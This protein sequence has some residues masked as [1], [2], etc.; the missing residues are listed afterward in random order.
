M[1]I[2]NS[3]GFSIISF[4]FVLGVMIFIHELGHYAV[5]KFLGIR[6]E[7][8]SLGFGRR[9]VGFKKGDT[10]YRICLLPL[11]GYVKMAGENYDD[12]LS[13]DPG[14]FMSHSKSNRFAVAVAGPLMNIGLALILVAAT[15]MLGIPVAKY[16]RQ[17]AIIGSI[18]DGSPAQQAGLQL[19]D[20]I[21]A[22]DQESIPTWQEAELQIS[23]SPDQELLFSIKRDDNVF[24]QLV[25]TTI[26]EGIETGTIGVGPFIPYIV[27]DLEANTPA[28]KAGLQVGDEIIQV[29][30]GKKIGKG[31]SSSAELIN[32]SE[33][34]PLEFVIQRNKQL[35]ETTIAPE[36]IED[37]W[38]IGTTVQVMELEQHGVWEA[39]STSAKRNYRLT[40]LT[41]DVV[42]RIITG[43]TSLKTMSGPIEI[44][45]FSGMAASMG[46]VHLLNFMALVS[47]QLGIFNLMPIPILDG[48]VIA[49][50][51]IEGLM[52]RDISV[53]VKERIFQVGFVFL[54][55]LMGIVIFND[56]A[57]TITIF[58]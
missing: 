4:L 25:T 49:L 57:K 3:I 43:R 28:A 45:R 24:D 40:T 13:G 53:R 31:F 56:L 22:I 23:I 15:F 8:F 20:T 12:K 55:L 19:G 6:V 14:E 2:L 48:G 34:V 41:F 35:F 29:S 37:Q 16:S 30:I 5:A 51:G 10:D 11:G 21:I 58:D 9:L 18:A 42:G 17:P 33:G 47:L 50:L 7:V 1:T 32:N 39:F 36:Q 26:R 54:I 46:V 44:A 38:R 52:R 27:A